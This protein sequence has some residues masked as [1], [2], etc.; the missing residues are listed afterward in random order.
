[1]GFVDKDKLD[2]LVSQ[3]EDKFREMGLT[4]LNIGG[5]FDEEG[6]ILIQSIALVRESAYRNIT[7]DLE[8]REQLN[9]IA[10]ADHQMELDQKA[11]AIARAAEGGY[12]RDV[13]LGKRDL[14]E[15]SHE[16]IHEGL[17]LDCQKEVDDGQKEE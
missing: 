5:G 9:Q 13:L 12:M 3:I 4:V 17:C 15:C 11:E 2:Q 1:M 14:I 8:T 7:Q 10:A 16:R 6:N